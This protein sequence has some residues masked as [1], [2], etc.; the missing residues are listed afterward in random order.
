[1]GKESQCFARANSSGRTRHLRGNNHPV[2]TV[3]GIAVTSPVGTWRSVGSYYFATYSPTGLRQ[4]GSFVSWGRS[5]LTLQPPL[6]Q[7]AIR[8]SDNYCVSSFPCFL[9]AVDIFVCKQPSLYCFDA[10]LRDCI[11]SH[12]TSE[13]VIRQHHSD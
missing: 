5:P 13:E 1:M 4:S 8:E 2:S 9:G 12:R 10:F 6:P 3:Q 7:D 11:S